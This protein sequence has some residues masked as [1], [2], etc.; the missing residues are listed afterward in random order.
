MIRVLAMPFAALALCSIIGCASPAKTTPVPQPSGDYL[1]G[2]AR[3]YEQ[4]TAPHR[5]AV[6]KPVRDER[7]L[8]LRNLARETDTLLA[9][10]QE[11]N[12]DLRLAAVAESERPAAR[13]ALA[14]LY[15]SLVDLRAAATNADLTAVRQ[16]YPRVVA[17]YSRLNE[18]LR[19]TN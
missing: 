5:R 11:W 2:I 9:Q 3:Y 10:P 1:S 14:A 15:T 16:Q 19:Q 17:S 6:R 12:T 8:A 18:T 4:A 7:A 13:D